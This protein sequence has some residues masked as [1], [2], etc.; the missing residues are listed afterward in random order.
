MNG[1]KGEGYFLY[2]KVERKMKRCLDIIY[3]DVHIHTY[4]VEPPNN[5][6]IGSGTFVRYS[7]VSLSRRVL[8]NCSLL[9]F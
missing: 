1:G 2:R 9:P 5:G 8:L 4:T 3:K 7:E 6:H